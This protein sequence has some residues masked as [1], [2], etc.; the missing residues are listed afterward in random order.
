[1]DSGGSGKDEHEDGSPPI[2]LNLF[3]LVLDKFGSKSFG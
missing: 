1:M 3:H 2:L